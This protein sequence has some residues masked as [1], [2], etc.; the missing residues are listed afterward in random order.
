MNNSSLRQEMVVI[1]TIA[2]TFPVE[3]EEDELMHWP[4]RHTNQTPWGSFDTYTHNSVVENTPIKATYNPPGRRYPEPRLR[5]EASLPIASYG[6]N[7]VQFTDIAEVFA[8]ALILNSMVENIPGIPKVDTRD[9][10]LCR[11]D[12]CCN[13][14]VGDMVHEYIRAFFAL[15]YPQRKTRPYPHEGVQFLAKTI[16]TKFYSK[17]KECE[18]PEAIG[19]LRQ[20]TTIWKNYIGR[21]M[22]V[23]APTLRDVKPEWVA[24]MLHKDLERLHLDKQ[25]VCPRHIAQDMLQNQ[26]GR[27]KG[28]RLYGYLIERQTKGREQMLNSGYGAVDMRRND[29]IHRGCRRRARMHRCTCA[30]ARA[31]REVG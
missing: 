12:M 11:L 21:Q 17:Y 10:E 29:K 7:V 4:F 5:L 19:I 9:G 27:N 28:N 16:S 23:S 30:I 3:L 1:D 18:A 15:D 2:V 20:E 24:H 14:Q 25:M 26:Y 31:T 8:A 22:D 13:H 6:N